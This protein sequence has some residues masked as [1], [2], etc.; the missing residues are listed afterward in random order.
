MPIWNYESEN[1]RVIFLLLRVLD[2][3]MLYLNY[4]ANPLSPFAPQI[5]LHIM[6]QCQSKSSAGKSGVQMIDLHIRQQI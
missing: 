5:Y 1:I 3:A 2:L 6:S 4:D